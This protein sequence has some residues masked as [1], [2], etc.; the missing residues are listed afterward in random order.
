MNVFSKFDVSPVEGAIRNPDNPHHFMVLKPVKHSVKIFLGD[1]ILASTQNA[2]R[3]IEIGRKA[4][5]PVLYVPTKDVVVS[6][7]TLERNSFCPL[8]G[9]ATY[10]GYEGEEIAWSY[11]QPLAFAKELREYHAFWSSKTWIEEGE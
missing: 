1:N 2:I 4:Y 7:K 6:L 11:S 10:F 8:K 5:D 9:E 3:V